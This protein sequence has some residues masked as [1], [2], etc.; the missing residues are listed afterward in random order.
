MWLDHTSGGEFELPIG[1]VVKFSDQGQMQ[2]VDDE[3]E[4]HWVS[5]QNAS[6]IKIMHPTSVQG[7]EDMV[8]CVRGAGYM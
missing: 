7:V 3:G 2:L 5:S 8:R 4:D 1:A 6:K